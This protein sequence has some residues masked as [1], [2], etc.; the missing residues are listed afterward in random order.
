MLP[1][2]SPLSSPPVSTGRLAT[3][4]SRLGRSI[5]PGLALSAGIAALAMAVRQVPGVGFLSQMILAIVIGALIRN[6]LGKP[7]WAAA[8]VAFSMRRVLRLGIVLLGLQLTLSQV[9]AVGLS[10]VMLLAVALVS[11]FAF[12]VW[13]GR[14]LGVDPKLAQLIGAGT[15]I[16][17]ASAVLAADTVVQAEDADVAYGVASVTIFGSIAMVIYPMIGAAL[18]LPPHAFGLWAGASIHEIAQVVAATFTYGREA[19]DFGTIAKLTRV[20]MLA[21]AVLG[22]GL[23][24]SRSSGGGRRARP[25]MPWF[26]LG[27]VALTAVNSVVAVP[28]ELRTMLAGGTMFL[29]SMALAAMGLETDYRRLRLKG[30]MPLVLGFAASVF[31]S[32]ISL[33]MVIALG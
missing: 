3:L 9:A 26:V 31:I 22:L 27:F 1:S 6:A 18:E 33:A 12:T 23:I 25:P 5:L 19:G 11:T 7:G 30:A 32:A 29:L 2:P 4:E 14:R 16:C 15:S 17:G 21:P 20:M 13:L 10:G 8:G 24:L 28:A